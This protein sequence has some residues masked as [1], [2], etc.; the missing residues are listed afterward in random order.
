MNS[1]DEKPEFL[2]SFE[3]YLAIF[4]RHRKRIYFLSSLFAMSAFTYVASRPVAYEVE[5]TFREQGLSSSDK[6]DGGLTSLMALGSSSDHQSRAI[7]VLKSKNLTKRLIETLGLQADIVPESEQGIPFYN[8]FRNIKAEGSI[9]LRHSRPGVSDLVRPIRAS[10]VDYPQEVGAQF[11]ITIID[12]SNYWIEGMGLKKT[13]GTFGE[14][15]IGDGY[16]FTLNLAAPSEEKKFTLYILPKRKVALSLANKIKI[17]PDPKDKRVVNLKIIHE[18]RWLSSE[19]LNRLMGLYREW[20]EEE[21]KKVSE[22]QIAYL[23]QREEEENKLL[24]T[25]LYKHAM[26]Q[27]SKMD[28]SGFASNMLA[29][30]FMTKNLQDY[31]EKI[32]AIN[33]EVER[34]SRLSEGNIDLFDVFHLTNI[35]QP[36]NALLTE[37]RTLK[38]EL[39]A[40]ALSIK[41]HPNP[42]KEEIADLTKQLVDI[43]EVKETQGKLKALLSD[44]KSEKPLVLTGKLICNRRCGLETWVEKIETLKRESATMPEAH[45]R[46][47]AQKELASVKEQF[48]AYLNNLIH[49][50]QIQE[51]TLQ[52]RLHHLTDVKG[53]VEGMGLVPTKELLAYY[54][55]ELSSSESQIVKNSFLVQSIR[56]KDVELSPLSSMIED[57]IGKEIVGRYSKLMLD[58][59]NSSIRSQKEQERIKEEL[60]TQ[61]GYLEN[62]IAQSTDIL[63][64]K[65]N[66]LKDAIHN[67]QTAMLGLY[68]EQ[69]ALFEKQIT[70][71]INQRVQ[72]ML[73]EKGALYDQI[74]LIRDELKLMPEKRIQEIM[75]EQKIDLLK[76]IYAQIVQTI[77]AKNLQSSLEVVQSVPIDR[78]DIPYFPKNPNLLLLTLV[79]AF[80]GFFTAFVYYICREGFYGLK[81][82]MRNLTGAGLFV[83]GSLTPNKEDNPY[84]AKNS[85]LE[86]LRRLIARIKDDKSILLLEGKGPHYAEMLGSLFGSMGEKTLVISLAFENS[87]E[88]GLLKVLSEDTGKIP[89]V[90]KGLYD[91]L[92]SGGPSRL[93]TEKLLSQAFKDLLKTLENEYDRIIAYSPDGPIDGSALPKLK[94]FDHV[95]ATV[96]LEPA[97]EIGKVAYFMGTDKISFVFQY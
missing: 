17:V 74:F 23:R 2:A 97:Q 18:D 84:L 72:A 44:L 59:Q 77:E 19:I 57:P 93:G 63:G 26:D 96:G 1:R 80:L 66:L 39:D 33:M 68:R 35:P 73:Q 47:E 49:Y 20:L 13:K 71:F 16:S 7:T 82:S 31:V 85:D 37:I 55:K 29:M 54:N 12:G 4:K 70:D 6:K 3:D 94:L 58:L 40:L 15:F 88:Q 34:L 79:G 50:F 9:L 81:A 22:E 64:L 67:L 10:K 45:K 30:D 27:A 28:S 89:I 48:T 87:E 41:S 42:E 75:I 56:N 46:W 43:D 62:H 14:P 21:N 5:A 25:M 8:L 24:T 38:L 78:A 91:F 11:Y 92:P 65:A 52:E 36:V 53:D 60:L 90:N 95:I 32:T 86:T 69:I 51:Q 83:A 76:K 61:R